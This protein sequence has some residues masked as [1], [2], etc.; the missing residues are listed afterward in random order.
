MKRSA[1][2][3]VSTMLICIAHGAAHAQTIYPLNRAE[4]LVGAKFDLKVEFPD[5]PAAASVRV[6]I[7]GE[8]AARVIGTSATITEREEGGNFTAYWLRNAVLGKPGRYVIE[9]TAGDRKA[10]V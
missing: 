8:D 6:T 7:N 1:A 9:A 5:A 2:I 3:C 10:S 4:L